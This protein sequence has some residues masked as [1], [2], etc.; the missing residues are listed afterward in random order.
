MN[1][2]TKHDF[3]L[4][5]K[6][7]YIKRNLGNDNAK[8]DLRRFAHHLRNYEYHG[9]YCNI[10]SK[11]LLKA[12]II[13]SVYELCSKGIQHNNIKTLL[14]N[15]LEL[16]I[17]LHNNPSKTDIITYLANQIF[18]LD[19]AQPF[20]IITLK[21]KDS[22]LILIIEK[23]SPTI[24]AQTIRLISNLLSNCANS[25]LS[26]KEIYKKLTHHLNYIRKC[27]IKIHSLDHIKS[28]NDK[29]ANI[30][31][32]IFNYYNAKHISGYSKL[33]ANNY[34]KMGVYEKNIICS[35][36][37]ILAKTGN[38]IDIK[39]KK[40]IS[41][42][43]KTSNYIFKNNINNIIEHTITRLTNNDKYVIGSLDR[44]FHLNQ[45]IKHAPHEIKQVNINELD[46]Y[47][48]QNLKNLVILRIKKLS[49]LNNYVSQLSGDNFNQY[50]A[51][52]DNFIPQLALEQAK[53]TRAKIFLNKARI[54]DKKQKHQEAIQYYSKTLELDPKFKEAY[55]YRANNYYKLKKY[56]N[57][58]EDYSRAINTDPKYYEAYHKRGLSYA[59]TKQL[60]KAIL[61]FNNALQ[62]KKAL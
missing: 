28:N 21:T 15:S 4:E 55:F 46:F 54:L 11:F 13:K 17:N 33:G 44:K 40:I 52:N 29:E 34:K 60:D 38:Y 50:L 35:I 26:H 2:D 37:Y 42:T 51:K 3:Q 5:S 14:Y 43:H 7:N 47:G 9:K 61:D 6:I 24:S 1:I 53:L 16:N 39:N 62:L 32:K 8:E 19:R 57:A 23:L 58:I 48:L 10:F 59:E 31:I 22:D 18:S 12:E 20:F 25:Q 56:N 30:N 27:P 36:S 49:K 45:K 41:A